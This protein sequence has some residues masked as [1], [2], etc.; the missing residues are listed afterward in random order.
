MK[1]LLLLRHAKTV[2]GGPALPDRDRPLTERG[3][4]DASLVGAAIARDTPPETVIFSP[5]IRTR[6]TMDEVLAHLRDEPELVV[7]DPL[8]G[9]DERVYLE[10]I[11]E[12]AGTARRVLVIGHNP[13][14]H[15]LAVALARS[16]GEKLRAKFPTSALAVIGFD[17][18]S[19]STMRPGTGQLQ[20]YL[21]PKDL[22]AH[23]SED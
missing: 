23:D 20:T 10:T 9:G 14:I 7:A 2:P 19:W 21:R 1:H 22:G 3:H 15:S 12:H 6:Q 5:A 13:T 11:R 4:R 8:Y 18:D 16:P 17:I